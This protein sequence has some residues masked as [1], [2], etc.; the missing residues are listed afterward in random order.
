M[1]FFYTTDDMDEKGMGVRFDFADLPA[2]R[3]LGNKVFNAV[4]IHGDWLRLQSAI[5]EITKQIDTQLG[6]L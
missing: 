4:D 6:A 1:D 5:H 3:N 2:D